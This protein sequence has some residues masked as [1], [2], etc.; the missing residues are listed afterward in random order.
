MDLLNYSLNTVTLLALS[1]IVGI[2]VD[3]AIVEVEN[4][5]R[6]MHMGKNAYDASMEAADEIGLAVIATSFTLIAVFLPTAFMSGVIGIIFKQFGITAS[7]AVLCSLLV[8]RFV[9]PMMAAYMMKTPSK[10][11]SGDGWMMRRYIAVVRGELRRRWIPVLGVIL[12]FAATVLLMGNLSTGF[13]PASDDSQTQISI[14]TTPGS[15][16]EQTDAVAKKA[17]SLAAG[18]NHMVAITPCGPNTGS[19]IRGTWVS[20]TFSHLIRKKFGTMVTSSGTISADI[21]KSINR[22]APAKRKGISA[23]QIGWMRGFHARSET[24]CAAQACV[25]D[26]HTRHPHS[27]LWG[28]RNHSVIRR[29][30]LSRQRCP[31]RLGCT[32]NPAI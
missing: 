18:V 30:I 14:T 6:H 12:F 5:E 31:D 13:F 8:A 23:H 2:L 24:Y 22:A 4:I 7:V 32:A 10:T 17:A 15:T 11:K 26:V 28:R 20:I 3:D 29:A 27:K 16:I 9:T 19:T 25:T 1:L 21:K